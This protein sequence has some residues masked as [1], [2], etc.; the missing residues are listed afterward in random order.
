MSGNVVR[1]FK[2]P[3]Q[4]VPE[5]FQASG[6]ENYSLRVA[7]RE[8]FLQMCRPLLWGSENRNELGE[9][10][11]GL[12]QHFLPKNRWQ[13]ELLVG[14]ADAAW[15]LRRLRGLQYALFNAHSTDPGKDGIP[16]N[17]LTAMGHEKEV[18]RARNQL[19]LA[20]QTYHM[21]SKRPT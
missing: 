5:A 17:T 1:L 4:E 6:A 7:D 2:L 11:R 19:R 8:G 16:N 14:V 3:E 10:L 12:V 21:G 18:E 13:L 15:K 9:L 20:V